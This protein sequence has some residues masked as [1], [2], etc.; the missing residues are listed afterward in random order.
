MA[1]LAGLSIAFWMG[2]YDLIV[3]GIA[4]GIPSTL[5]FF[6]LLPGGRGRTVSMIERIVR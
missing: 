5:L 6:D 4:F 2:R 1:H 3:A